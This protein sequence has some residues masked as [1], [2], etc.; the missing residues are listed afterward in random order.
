M[1]NR[2]KCLGNNDND[3]IRRLKHLLTGDSASMQRRSHEE[4]HCP[5]RGDGSKVVL[6]VCT[7][8]LLA[9]W[10]EAE[11]RASY[12]WAETLC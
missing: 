4:L 2:R 8:V 6:S 11:K 9:L 10:E 3:K 1:T 5:K 12:S 7:V